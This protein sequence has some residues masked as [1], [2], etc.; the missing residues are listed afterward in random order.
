MDIND[1][2]SDSKCYEMAYASCGKGGNMH[3]RAPGS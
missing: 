1:D 3:V 2:L